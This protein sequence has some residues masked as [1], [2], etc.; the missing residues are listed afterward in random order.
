MTTAAK[1]KPSKVKEKKPTAKKKNVS[2]ASTEVVSKKDKVTAKKSVTETV[3]KPVNKKNQVD[4]KKEDLKEFS[5]DELLEIFGKKGS[6]ERSK[7]EIL[8]NEG[9]T[10][11]IADIQAKL[12]Q[13]KEP[14]TIIEE[15]KVSEP[16][17]EKVLPKGI[18]PADY[19][20]EDKG[21]GVSNENKEKLFFINRCLRLFN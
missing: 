17:L 16:I 6:E 3:K 13:E 1:Q 9:V 11:L 19:I 12:K 8:I 5:F 7:A 10:K 18:V 4:I 14:K 15:K 21:G 2:K 20:P